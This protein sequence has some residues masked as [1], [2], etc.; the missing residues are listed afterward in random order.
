MQSIK[1][2][3]HKIAGFLVIQTQ[4]GEKFAHL[5]LMVPQL[6]HKTQGLG[7]HQAGDNQKQHMVACWNMCLACVDGDGP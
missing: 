3:V 7:G 4:L 2:L 1:S 5:T 6:I